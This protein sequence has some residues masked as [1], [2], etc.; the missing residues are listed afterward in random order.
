MPL[1]IVT[2]NGSEFANEL[3]TELAL[4]LG[5]KRSF[6]SPYNSKC[7]GKVENAHKTM[8]T[9]VRA[10]IED[11]P[12]DWD[13]L[14]PLV[15]F[16]MN[17]SKSDVTKYTPFFLHFGRHPIMPLDALLGSIYKPVISTSEYV[18]QLE[19]QRKRVFAWV[20]QQKEKAADKMSK[21]WEKDHKKMSTPFS[22]GD[23]VLL[24]NPKRVGDYG[25]KYNPIYHKEIYCIEENLNNGSYLI[26]DLKR[27][28]PPVVQNIQNLKKLTK[29]FEIDIHM[30]DD[31]ISTNP[32]I[33]DD[34]QNGGEPHPSNQEEKDAEEDPYFEVNQIVGHR[35]KDGINQYKV[36]WKGYRK[37]SAQW[38]DE[39]TINAQDAL[40]EYH[41]KIAAKA[42]AKIAAKA[43][44]NGF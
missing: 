20:L 8:Q 19:A 36:W 31:T 1:K 7:N 43:T 26:R 22:I 38:C 30:H 39:D 24:R 12:E 25:E 37:S 42:A 32:V 13:L 34:N 4:L 5:L 16:A 40:K 6:I 18:Q 29:K 2:D 14:I 28:Q 11:Y 33:Y 44:N 10:Y 21:Q 3:M 9:M 17:T 27:S 35:K 23:T 41:T 15:E